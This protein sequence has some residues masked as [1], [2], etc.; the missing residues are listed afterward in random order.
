VY[1]VMWIL[2]CWVIA[3]T[4]LIVIATDFIFICLTQILSMEFDILTQLISEIDMIEGEDEAAKE[5]K[6]LLCVHQE[7]IEVSEKLSDVFSVLL[8]INVFGSI[9]TL[10][11]TSFLVVVIYIN[12]YSIHGLNFYLKKN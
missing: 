2:E 4:M 1:G 3:N 11:T 10:C 8:F 5:L 7:L 6:K 9:V 12:S